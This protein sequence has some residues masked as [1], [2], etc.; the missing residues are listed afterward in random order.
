MWPF[1]P[2][3]TNLQTCRP[4]WTEVSSNLTFSFFPET[5]GTAFVDLDTKNRRDLQSCFIWKPVDIS[6]HGKVII[7]NNQ[8]I[9]INTLFIQFQSFEQ[10]VLGLFACVMARRSTINGGVLAIDLQAGYVFRAGGPTL[11]VVGRWD[12]QTVRIQDSLN[13]KYLNIRFHL[14]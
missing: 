4:L 10:F 7:L 3:T 13:G 2:Y 8:T 9:H 12:D 14:A 1:K 6:L 11:W 5:I